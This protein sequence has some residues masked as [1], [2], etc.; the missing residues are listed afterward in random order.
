MLQIRNLL[1][2][3]KKDFRVLLKDM[4]FSLTDGDKAVIIGEEGNGKSTLIKWI[5]DPESISSYAE[6]EGQCILGNER[7]GYLRQEMA[8]EETELTLY[9]YFT[10]DP[11]FW[12]RTPKELSATAAQIGFT[13]DIFYGE[14]KVGT[15]S[16]GEK[17]KV[18][19]LRLMIAE[20]TVLLLDEPSNDIDLSTL[21]WM[22]TFLK[23]W[24]HIVLF[25][26]HDETLIRDV[27]NVIIH[28]EQV[29]RKTVFRYTVVHDTYDNY[30]ARRDMNFAHQEQLA[31]K[32]R[33]EKVIRDEKY[34][35]IMQKVE[36]AQ[37][38]I[39]R[40]DAH[41][42]RLLKKKMHAVKSLGHRYKRMDEDMT[43]FPEQEEA[44]YFRL[45]ENSAPVPGSKNVLELSLPVLNTPD[46]SRV[47]ARN[48]TL[49]I[50]GPEKICIVGN[51]GAGKTTL[52]RKIAEQML[53]RTDM[54]C[55]YMP[56]NYEDLLNIAIT[57]IE[58]LDDTEDKETRTRIRTFLGALKYTTDEMDHPVSELSGGQKAKIFLLKM[59]MSGANVL[60]L[61]E[62]TRN[63]SPLSGPVIRHMLREFPGVI[64]SISHDRNYIREVCDT[65]YELTPE[66]L[67]K[68]A[69]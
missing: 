29:R 22:E 45:G 67:E 1:V 64:I 46:D 24:P 56:Q 5:A 43:H 15:L 63:F 58:Y 36:H 30:L 52:L 23:N 2:T 14:Q 10:S 55:E 59:S 12:D 69:D 42:G 48:I 3:H 20:P 41:G 4:S 54:H 9:E 38:V 32:E 33:R 65:V 17:V 25:V 68:I 61:D 44:I 18:Q 47:L 8:P 16:G 53:P 6:A 26:S 28:I 11:V 35:R 40:Q 51:N 21:E 34:R 39:T 31:Q 19:L 66:G 50:R 60:I 49:K 57:P 37:N 13:T 27:A 62:P 7:I